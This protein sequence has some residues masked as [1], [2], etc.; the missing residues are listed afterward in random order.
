MSLEQLMSALDE[1]KAEMPEGAYLEL[2]NVAKEL[3]KVCSLLCLLGTPYQGTY[4]TLLYS[5]TPHTRLITKRQSHK[6]KSSH[7]YTLRVPEEKV[8]PRTLGIHLLPT[9]VRQRV[10]RVMVL[11][12]FLLGT[13]GGASLLR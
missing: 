13:T 2:C 12:D 7:G 1:H 5:H 6:I 11:S 8:V 4:K 3:Q 10:G 9:Q